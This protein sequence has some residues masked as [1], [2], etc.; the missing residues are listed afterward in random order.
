MIL[1]FSLLVPGILFA[2]LI[3]INFSHKKSA[4]IVSLLSFIS[5]PVAFY[6]L[7]VASECEGFGGLVVM[8]M[9]CIFAVQALIFCG[10]FLNSQEPEKRERKA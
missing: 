6:D 9:S 10:I 4:G 8:V 5:A 3:A 2:I 1:I 7:C